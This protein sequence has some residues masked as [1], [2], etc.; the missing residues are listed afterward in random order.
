MWVLD[1]K[2]GEGE[3]ADPLLMELYRAQVSSYRD[4]IGRAYPGRRVN[5]AVVFTDGNV[6]TLED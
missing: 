4:A 5:A 2:T 6:L 1:Y 3:T